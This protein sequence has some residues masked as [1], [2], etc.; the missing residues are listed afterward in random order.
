MKWH[1]LSLIQDKEIYVE[2][3]REKEKKV[4]ASFKEILGWIFGLAFP[5]MRVWHWH[6]VMMACS[7]YRMKWQYIASAY[8]AWVGEEIK[9]RSSIQ[10][11]RVT[12]HYYTVKLENW[13]FQ[14]AASN[15][16]WVISRWVWVYFFVLMNSSVVCW[17]IL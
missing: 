8:I 9:E 2:E 6:R 11:Q 4:K 12:K 14:L 16:M 15:R 10:A 17:W 13:M 1:D 7:P 5:F 3:S